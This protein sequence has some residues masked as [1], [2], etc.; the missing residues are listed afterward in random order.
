M[1]K[2]RKGILGEKLGMTQVWDA[3][4]KLVPVTVRVGLSDGQ[5]SEVID[6]LAEGD[7]VVVGEAGAAGTQQRQ[8]RRGPF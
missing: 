7:K 1:N 6:G 5:R 3:G 4:N 2:E 8:Q